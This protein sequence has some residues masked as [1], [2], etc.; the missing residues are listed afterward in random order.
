MAKFI[1]HK[2]EDYAVLSNIHLKDKNLS[3]KAK[4]LLSLM[5]ALPA[6]WQYSVSGL[7]SICKEGKDAIMSALEELADCKYITITT[8]RNDKGQFETNYDIYEQPYAESQPMLENRCGKSESDNPQEHNIENKYKNNNPLLSPYGDL[9]FVV[10]EFLPVVQ[11]WLEYK[12]ARRQ[13]YTTVMGLRKMYNNLFQMSGGDP[14]VAAQ[15]VSQSIGNNYSGLFPL[16]TNDTAKSN[17]ATILDTITGA[18]RLYR[19]GFV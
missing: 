7:A 2:T 14:D 6:D 12:K 11:E 1:I 13:T 16:R 17:N 5:L 9:S 10:P 15:I 4:G 3:L 19:K 18:E 8:Y